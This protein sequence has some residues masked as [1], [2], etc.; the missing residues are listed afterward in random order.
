MN[1]EPRGRFIPEAGGR[2]RRISYGGLQALHAVRSVL[3]GQRDPV[4][5]GLRLD[6]DYAHCKGCG[7]CETVCPFQ[8]I[9]MRAGGEAV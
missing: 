2:I 5:D 1:R 7:I 8:A 9:T 3:P 6:F 4:K